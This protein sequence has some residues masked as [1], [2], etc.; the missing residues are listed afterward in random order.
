MAALRS[1]CFAFLCRFY[2]QV[3]GAWA[4][5]MLSASLLS[6]YWDA[7]PARDYGSGITTTVEPAGWE[8]IWILPGPPPLQ[9]SVTHTHTHTRRRRARLIVELCCWSARCLLLHRSL[10]WRVC[11]LRWEEPILG[12]LVSGAR[13][14]IHILDKLLLTHKYT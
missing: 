6:S 3:F 4:A 1:F 13:S 2:Q 12:R 7:S 9:F 8:E 10:N 11:L 14:L 5:D